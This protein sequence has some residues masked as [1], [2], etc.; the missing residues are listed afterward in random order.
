MLIREFEWAPATNIPESSTAELSAAIHDVHESDDYVTI[1]DIEVQDDLMVKVSGEFVVAQQNFFTNLCAFLKYPKRN[2]ISDLETGRVAGDLNQLLRLRDQDTDVALRFHDGVLY[3][4]Y[5]RY[6]KN[7]HI[8]PHMSDTLKMLDYYSGNLKNLCGNVSGL[9]QVINGNMEVCYLLE[10]L[11]VAFEDDPSYASIRFLAKSDIWPGINSGYVLKRTECDNSTVLTLNKSWK[12]ARNSPIESL[13]AYDRVIRMPERYIPA[14]STTYS[15]LVK[16]PIDSELAFMRW[17]DHA[18]SHLGRKTDSILR[19]WLEKDVN[20]A[21]FYSKD[22]CKANNKSNVY[23]FF[24]DIT[25]YARQL[26]DEDGSLE[27]EYLRRAQEY[28]GV[29]FNNFLDESLEELA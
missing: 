17:R 20:G 27:H 18:K 21:M 12:G 7:I 8:P 10:G 25:Y 6:N 16:E 11:N 15:K 29:V 28:A 1:G 2:L 24:N 5:P 19:K 14:L 4:G 9:G 22:M 23:D 26:L 3:A 13:D